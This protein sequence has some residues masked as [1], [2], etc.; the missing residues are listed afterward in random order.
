M[1]YICTHGFWYYVCIRLFCLRC[2]EVQFGAVRWPVFLSGVNPCAAAGSC[3]SGRG[4]NCPHP[5]NVVPVDCHLSKDKLINQRIYWVRPLGGFK[6]NSTWLWFLWLRTESG[7]GC[8]RKQQSFGNIIPYV[9]LLWLALLGA[10]VFRLLILDLSMDL[11]WRPILSFCFS[12]LWHQG[13]SDI[14]D[15]KW[16][17]E[18]V[19]RENCSSFTVV[20]TILFPFHLNT[21]MHSDTGSHYEINDLPV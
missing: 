13:E 17:L 18:S 16:L 2:S 20:L 11:E 5:R 8:N 4:P 3:G 9:H 15:T 7:Y 10:A 21:D 6:C 19:L 14:N 12:W 1:E